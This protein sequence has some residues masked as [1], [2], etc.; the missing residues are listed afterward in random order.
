M[1]I[2]FF[3]QLREGG[4]PVSLKEYLAFLEALDKRVVDLDAEV[5]LGQIID[6]IKLLLAE[7]IPADYLAKVDLSKELPPLYGAMLKNEQDV[8][9]FERLRF[10]QRRL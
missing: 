6:W 3:L 10:M 2:E 8:H 5:H 9:A 7:N 4:V 1:F